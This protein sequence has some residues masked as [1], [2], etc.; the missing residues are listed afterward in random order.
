MAEEEPWEGAF[1]NAIDV[2]RRGHFDEVKAILEVLGFVFSQ[3]T[4]PNHW[5]YFHRQLKEDPYFRYPRNLYRPHGARRSSDRISRHDQSQ[6]KQVIE[7]LR[8]AIGSSENSGGD[9]Q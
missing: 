5:L 1:D 9:N 7:A 2:V 8:G 6:A 4:D 3:T